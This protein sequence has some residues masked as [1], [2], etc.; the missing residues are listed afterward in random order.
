MRGAV[1][2]LN[3]NGKLFLEQFL[4]TVIE[5]SHEATIYVAD[6]ASTDGSIQFVV[7]N[8]PSVVVI[9]NKENLGY[10]GGYNLALSELKEESP[11]QRGPFGA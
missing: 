7:E 1:V 6:N 2:I 3:W 9:D 10:A 8:Y 4:Q 11:R 5:R